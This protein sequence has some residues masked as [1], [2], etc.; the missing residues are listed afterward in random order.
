MRAQGNKHFAA[1]LYRE[2][3]EVYSAA[4]K[5]LDGSGSV[6][7]SP[8]RGDLLAAC[9]SNRA[10][11]WL[12][13]KRWPEALADC[14]AVLRGGCVQLAALRFAQALNS[15]PPWSRRANTVMIK[16]LFRRGK[17][18]E[19]MGNADAAL[20]DFKRVVELEP[21][22]AAALEEA[23]TPAYASTTRCLTARR[24][25]VDNYGSILHRLVVMSYCDADTRRRQ[26]GC[27]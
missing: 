5:L 15:P 16:A 20:A 6:D 7:A 13:R 8:A 12:R 27:I 18:H 24:A 11:V 14:N 17:A 21:N 19:G 3:T 22:N 9:L 1:G 10:A 4:I 26:Q 23:R 2:A 25:Q